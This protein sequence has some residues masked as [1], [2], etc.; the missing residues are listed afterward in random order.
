MAR[1]AGTD[2]HLRR[3]IETVRSHLSESSRQVHLAPPSHAFAEE[4]DMG[5]QGRHTLVIQNGT[6]INGTGNP[7]TPNQAMVIE[8]NRIKSIG[9]LPEELAHGDRRHIEIIDAAG[10]WIMPG[11]IDGHCHLS[12]GFPQMSGGPSTRGTTS[13]GFSALRA[14]RNAQQVLRTG[15]TSIAVPGG[16]WFN[17]VAIRDAINVGLIEGPR[18][19]CAG[20]FIVTY[21]GITDNEPSWVG[22]PEHT[23]GVLANDVS[24]MITEVRRQ[25]KHGV[26]FIKLADST[27]GDTQM[28]A[29]EELSAVVQEAHR[30]GA[31]VTIHSRGA[32]STRA[33]A[34]AGM[35]WILHADLATDTE[36]EVVAEAG[37]RLMPTMTFLRRGAEVGS[38]YGRGPREMDRL[39]RHWES[40]VH[41]LERARALG[42]AI[43]CG[44]DSGNSP[45]MPYGQLHAHEAE[46]LVRYGGYTPMAAIIASTK[47][48]AFAIGLEH[49]LG[50]LEPGKLADLII[51]KSDP[52]ADIRVLQGGQHLA[53]VIK[54]GKIVPLNG[55]GVEEAMLALAQPTPV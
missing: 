28:I 11:L 54:D 27:W 26:D 32:G 41:M 51:L 17:D 8:G 34:E 6:L 21:G 2:E 31:R 52:L 14:A 10:Q 50:T 33:A 30:R 48:T 15:V 19:A 42:I 16:T 12:F 45:L 37:V 35:D 20:R 18:I 9:P 1:I 36:L 25:C 47:N 23:I 22:T 4:I 7:P 43:M 24:E 55:H 39:K 29:P 40:A 53:T 44:T 38:E 46:I 49:D 5:S 3:Q 13:P